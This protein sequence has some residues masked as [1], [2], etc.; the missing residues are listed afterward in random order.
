MRGLRRESS[1]FEAVSLY[2][3]FDNILQRRQF[4]NFILDRA[5]DKGENI[6]MINQSMWNPTL[7]MPGLYLKPI[8]MLLFQYFPIVKEV[9]VQQPMQYSPHAW[10][11]VCP[12]EEG[13]EEEKKVRDGRDESLQWVADSS[14]L[15]AAPPWWTRGGRWR[16]SRWWRGSW[17]QGGRGFVARTLVGW[18]SLL[19]WLF[20]LTFDQHKNSHCNYQHHHLCRRTIGNR[21]VA[22]GRAPGVHPTVTA[23]SPYFLTVLKHCEHI[24]EMWFWWPRGEC[25]KEEN[26]KLFSPTAWQAEVETGA[27]AESTQSHL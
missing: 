26:Y 23:P 22:V 2:A 20:H 15:A 12:E 24:R 5:Q 13:E 27:G 10:S 1:A 3:A 9:L 6:I 16:T 7:T 25:H 4:M 18:S 14:W 8:F 21:V 11:N 19:C 17:S